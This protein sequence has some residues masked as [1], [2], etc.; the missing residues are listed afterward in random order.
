MRAGQFRLCLPKQLPSLQLGFL[1]D[2]L[3][4]PV[5]RV[6]ELIRERLRRDERVHEGRL[7]F[8]QL[9][10]M[11]LGGR[12]FLAQH[13]MV[14][15]QRLDGLCQFLQKLVH[16]LPVIPSQADLKHHFP[17]VERRD[18]HRYRLSVHARCHL[19]Q[20]ADERVLQED[21]DEDRDDR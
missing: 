4:V 21:D 13:R 10:E 16:V 12:Q 18:L 17:D 2:E 8:S 15:I 1:H 19:K 14:S 3:G 6:L 11:L 5:C 9:G 20:R 7:G